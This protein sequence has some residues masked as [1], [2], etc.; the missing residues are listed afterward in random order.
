MHLS[1][2]TI[3]MSIL[4]ANVTGAGLAGGM[5]EA[6]TRDLTGFKVAVIATDGVEESEIT[7]PMK[8]LKDAHATVEVIAPKSGSIQTMK[9]A[10]KGKTIPVDRKL[11][12]V[13]SENYNGLLLPGGALNADALRVIPEAKTFVIAFDQSKKP[14]AVICHAPWMLV[15]AN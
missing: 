8:A 13:Q 6:A 7:E 10:D 4:L 5:V 9:H 12:D 11:L 14:I 2:R 3:P 1:R 15:S